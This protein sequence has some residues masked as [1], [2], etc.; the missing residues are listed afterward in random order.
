MGRLAGGVG[1]V[2]VAGAD[3][4]G[5]PGGLVATP[6]SVMAPRADGF[7]VV[8]GVDGLCLGRVEWQEDGLYLT[9]DAELIAV[10]DWRGAVPVYA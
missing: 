2:G 10:C 6:V 4:G 9:G 5:G 1:A 8:W 3:A 7:E